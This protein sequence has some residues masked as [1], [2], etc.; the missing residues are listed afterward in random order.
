MFQNIYMCIYTYSAKQ[1]S[2]FFRFYHIEY[3]ERK[4]ILSVAD[5]EGAFS[6]LVK[7]TYGT[8]QVT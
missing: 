4:V 2:T 5:I 1:C 6:C 7:A 3:M 8:T